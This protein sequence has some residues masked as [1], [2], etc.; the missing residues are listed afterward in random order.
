MERRSKLKVYDVMQVSRVTQGSKKEK[1]VW[2]KYDGPFQSSIEAKDTMD[3]LN[4]D[5]KS[6]TYHTKTY[7]QKRTQISYQVLKRNA[8]AEEIQDIEDEE[9][10]FQAEILEAELEDKKAAAI[11]KPKEKKKKQKNLFD[12]KKKVRTFLTIQPQLKEGEKCP[13]IQTAY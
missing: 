5:V 2:S 9:N 13:E 6:T 3:D 12:E 4:R 7:P 10:E 1:P 8:T 11:V